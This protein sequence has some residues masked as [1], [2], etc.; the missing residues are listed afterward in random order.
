MTK[1]DITPKTLEQLLRE[2]AESSYTICSSNECPLRQSCLHWMA[3][4]YSPKHPFVVSTINLM[5][6]LMQTDQCPMY[7]SSRPIRMPLG[8]SKMYYDMPRR[9]EV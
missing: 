1:K 8:I 6:P 9:I 5:N 2:K 7:S 4:E 3:R